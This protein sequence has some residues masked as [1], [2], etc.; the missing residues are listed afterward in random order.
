MLAICIHHA[1]RLT[2]VSL[3]IERTQSIA[4]NLLTT[5]DNVDSGPSTEKSP[6]STRGFVLF[7]STTV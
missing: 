1:S 2:S 4:S 3:S 6:S 5:V 7:V